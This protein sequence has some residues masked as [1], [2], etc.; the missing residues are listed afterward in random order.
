MLLYKGRLPIQLAHLLTKPA[1]SIINQSFDSRLR[2]DNRRP[3]NG[4]GFGVGWYESEPDPELDPAPCIFTSVTPAWNNMNLIRLAE[5]IKSPLVF[6]HVRASTAGSVSESNCHPWQYG[7]LMFMHNGN[8]ANFH[9][10]KRKVQ[11]SLSDEIFLSVN[12]N[13]DS[14]WAFAVFLSLLQSPLQPE[15]FCHTK[16]K[17]A[18]LKT[19]AKLNAWAK[20]AGIIEASMMNFAVT[21]GVSVVCTRYISSKTL[22]AAS[23]YYS[24]GTRFESYKPGHYRMVK[25]DRREDI[26][27]I[28]SEPLTFEKADWLTI[29]TNTVVVITSKMNVLMYPIQDEYYQPDLKHREEDLS[30]VAVVKGEGRQD[31]ARDKECREVVF[32][33]EDRPLS[34]MEAAER[35]NVDTDLAKRSSAKESQGADSESSAPSTPVVSSR[36][37]SS[38][39][40]SSPSASSLSTL[41]SHVNDTALHSDEAGCGDSDPDV[42]ASNGNNERGHP[43]DSPSRNEDDCD[44]E[45]EEDYRIFPVRRSSIPMLISHGAGRPRSG[46][47]EEQLETRRSFA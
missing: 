24:S 31:G 47:S 40:P 28:A 17:D 25:A 3:I 42:Q 1:H 5:K 32:V 34:T 30:E 6:A 37:S 23:L 12:G 46:R 18:M 9:L 11:E 26:V 13:T 39:F 10:I 36:P 43:V 14:E 35:H 33:E 22:E 15:P 16:L 2:L 38:Y 4:D 21:D 41:S 44:D 45:I 19:I 20:D 7:R 8:I 29:P 27:V